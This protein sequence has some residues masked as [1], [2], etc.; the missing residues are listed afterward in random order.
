VNEWNARVVDDPAGFARGV[1]RVVM[2]LRYGIED[3]QVHQ[4]T[5]FT[6]EGDVITTSLEP[7]VAAEFRGFALPYELITALGEAIKPGPSRAE[8]ARLEQAL[9]VADG[10][11]DLILDRALPPEDHPRS[12]P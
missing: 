9:A 6:D 1:C 4:V 5:G 3:H 7:G 11:I 2:W 12:T 10:R 8:M